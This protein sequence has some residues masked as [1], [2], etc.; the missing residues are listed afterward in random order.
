MRIYI[1]EAAAKGAKLLL[2][3]EAFDLGWSH[4]VTETEASTIPDGDVC[5]VLR[6]SARNN[7]V[8]ICAGLIEKAGNQ[9]FN[10]AVIINPAG[11]V[12]IKHR[13]LNELSIGHQYYA[14]GDRLNV[15]HT[16]LGTLGLMICADGFAKNEVLSRSLCY[17]GADIILSPS[18]WALPADHIPD[19]DHHQTCVNEWRDVYQ[20][21][22]EEYSVYIAGL[23]NVGP[24]TAG[25][26]TGK[27]CIGCS[28][29]FGPDGKEILQGQYGPEAEMIMYADI[30]PVQRPA[31]GTDWVDRF[32]DYNEQSPV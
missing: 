14:Q 5:M 28:L 24:I 11:K 22:A 8:Y 18:A 19:N 2:L 31:R 10:S 15:C 27:N 13:K 1:D 23:S 7:D 32:I 25:P 26:W 17:M 4:P 12:L 3:P 20:P 30:E 16:E 29:L 9:I 6:E 21:V